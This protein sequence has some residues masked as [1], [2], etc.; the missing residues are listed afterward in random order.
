VRAATEQS[1]ADVVKWHEDVAARFG[2]P[3]SEALIDIFEEPSFETRLP[4][5]LW[6]PESWAWLDDVA[7]KEGHEG[8]IGGTVALVV[9]GETMREGEAD[10]YFCLAPSTWGGAEIPLYKW[11]PGEPPTVM[12]KNVWKMSFVQKVQADQWLRKAKGQSR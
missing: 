7:K 9:I 10:L 8:P 11:T 12:N 3:L 2:K 4:F 1:Y 6:F 5:D